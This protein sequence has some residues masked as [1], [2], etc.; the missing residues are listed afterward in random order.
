MK[1]FASLESGTGMNAL[2]HNPCKLL[3]FDLLVL[4]RW[5]GAR[6]QHR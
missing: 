2:P 4:A 1:Y 5:G 3:G 6:R